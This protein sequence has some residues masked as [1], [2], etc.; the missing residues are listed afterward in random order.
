M[1][2][3]PKKY[4]FFPLFFEVEDGYEERMRVKG[5]TERVKKLANLNNQFPLRFTNGN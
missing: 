4:N 3:E 1:E 5:V 2:N